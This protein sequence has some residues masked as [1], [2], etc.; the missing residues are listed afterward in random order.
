MKSPIAVFS[1]SLPTQSTHNKSLHVLLALCRAAAGCLSL[2]HRKQVSELLGEPVADISGAADKEVVLSDDT[3]ANS[4]VVGQNTHAQTA[5]TV[6]G[7]ERDV[8]GDH[9]L[10]DPAEGGGGG[11]YKEKY[12]FGCGA[13]KRIRIAAY[14]DI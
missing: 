4:A 1:N 14:Y 5:S 3:Q 7:D 12:T 9:S 8:L 11:R 10:T 13:Q 2:G 6:L